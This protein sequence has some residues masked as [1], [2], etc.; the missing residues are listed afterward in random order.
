MNPSNIT[1]DNSNTYPYVACLY[2]ENGD[3]PGDCYTRVGS[4]WSPVYDDNGTVTSTEQ[5]FY[6]D[7]DDSCRCDIFGPYTS[8]QKASE[9]AEQHAC[10]ADEGNGNEDADAMYT[11]M[12]DERI[13]ESDSNGAWAVYWET[14]GDDAHVVERYATLDQAEA[15]VE[16]AEISLKDNYPG[17]NLLC[18]YGVR[19]FINNTWVKFDDRNCL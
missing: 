2:G 11:R 4:A 9:A 13:G 7:G 6:D 8:E 3:S 16:R 19:Q 15:H 10:E 1:W 12:L 17:G 18:G 14:V 5:W